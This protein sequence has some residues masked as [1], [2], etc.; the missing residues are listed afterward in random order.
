V[1]FGSAGPGQRE[2]KLTKERETKS[3]RR[4]REEG[5]VRGGDA[6]MPDFPGFHTL[7]GVAVAR[8]G[9]AALAP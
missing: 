6:L 8:S 4:G 3:K 9:V 5:S 2:R 1:V 7:S